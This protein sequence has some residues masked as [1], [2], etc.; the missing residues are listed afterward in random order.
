LLVGD[1]FD[2]GVGKDAEESC[3]MAAKETA[4]ALVGVDV[5]D[6]PYQAEPVAGVF[7]ELGIGGLEEDLDPVEGSD[8]CFCL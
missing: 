4:E 2:A 8:D 6:R 3:G 1:E 5:A 7:G